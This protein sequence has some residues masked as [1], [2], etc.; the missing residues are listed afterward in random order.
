M[1]NTG[2]A[3]YMRTMHAYITYMHTYLHHTY[4]HTCMHAY[5]S[6][7]LTAD[8][9][10]DTQI[11]FPSPSLSL[12]L[13][14]QISVKI[15]QGKIDGIDHRVA[16]LKDIR[17]LATDANKKEAMLNITQEIIKANMKV[18]KGTFIYIPHKKQRGRKTHIA[19]I[20]LNSYV[21]CMFHAYRV[22]VRLF[23]CTNATSPPPPLIPLH[24]VTLALH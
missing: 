2:Q 1:H 7:R 3:V 21:P 23:F 12:P 17:Q 24:L 13:I 19:C 9:R 18:R 5:A 11:L 4:I 10:I 15:L 20:S 14:T 8:Q 6:P 22:R 16:K